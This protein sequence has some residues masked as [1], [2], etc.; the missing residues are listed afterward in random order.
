MFKTIKNA[1]KTPEIRKRIFTEIMNI[2]D[3]NEYKGKVRKPDRFG[4]GNSMAVSIIDKELWLAEKDDG[5]IDLEK[6]VEKLV[7]IQSI[8]DELE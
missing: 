8:I 6:T 7:K 2:A 1:F 5:L 4:T 3:K